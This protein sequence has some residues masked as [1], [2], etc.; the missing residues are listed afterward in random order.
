MI[1][2]F[3]DADERIV[4]R[5]IGACE[6]C[7]STDDVALRSSMTAYNFDGPCN[8][9]DDPNRDWMGCASCW[10]EHEAHWS[11]M[12]DEYYASRGC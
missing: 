8:S 1:E 11:A 10:A 3:T 7:Q 12:W 5:N 9:D 2:E 4:L 6:H